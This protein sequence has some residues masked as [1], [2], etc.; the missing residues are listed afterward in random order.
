[1]SDCCKL[2]HISEKR[3]RYYDDVKR[4]S[5]AFADVEIPDGRTIEQG[6]IYFDENLVRKVNDYYYEVDLCQDTYH[7]KVFGE[8]IEVSR[9]ALV[10]SRWQYFKKQYYTFNVSN[11]VVK[12]SHMPG[13]KTVLFDLPIKFWDDAESKNCS[14]TVS[15][16]RL[17]IQNYRNRTI[18]ILGRKENNVKVKFE[19]QLKDG[20]W[21]AETVSAGRFWYLVKESKEKKKELGLF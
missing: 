5:I 18:I 13:I 12:E 19:Y 7:M 15:V 10:N 14:V 8:T 16:E 6:I 20:S 9:S 1:M 17:V 4:Y 3:V 21:K 11:R 2:G